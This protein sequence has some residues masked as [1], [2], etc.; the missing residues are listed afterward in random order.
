[1]SPDL[2]ELIPVADKF[3]AELARAWEANRQTRWQF[4]KQYRELRRVSFTAA[5]QS[6]NGRKLDLGRVTVEEIDS[7]LDPLCSQFVLRM[8]RKD[9]N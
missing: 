4:R 8:S 7:L 2:L 5:R 6:A 9:L 1:M 3:E